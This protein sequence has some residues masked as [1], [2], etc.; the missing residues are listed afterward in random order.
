[1]KAMESRI[2][3]GLDELNKAIQA[4]ENARTRADL[5]KL[6]EAEEGVCLQSR[7]LY[8]RYVDASLWR[9]SVDEATYMAVLRVLEAAVNCL[10]KTIPNERGEEEDYLV[11]KSVA[12]RLDDFKAFSSR[13]LADRPA[14][15]S[16][17]VHA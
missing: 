11:Q 16:D 5:P 3:Q 9:G 2:R 13:L 7:R 10:P 14:Q 15:Q 12:A 17:P 8:S 4:V 1:M 6:R